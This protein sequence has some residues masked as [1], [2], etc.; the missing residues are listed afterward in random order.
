MLPVQ[1]G[2]IDIQRDAFVFGVDLQSLAAV[3][4]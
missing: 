3:A 1:F 4:R 2:R